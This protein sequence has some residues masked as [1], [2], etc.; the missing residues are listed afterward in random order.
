VQYD[1]HQTL[2]LAR[3]TRLHVGNALNRLRVQSTVAHNPKSPD[4]FG[5]Q[6]CSVG[7]KCNRPR[8]LEITGEHLDAK[9]SLFRRLNIKRSVRELGCRPHDRRRRVGVVQ[10]MWCKRLMTLL[11]QTSRSRENRRES[12]SNRV[13]TTTARL[14]SHYPLPKATCI[15]VFR[16]LKRGGG[17]GAMELASTAMP[18]F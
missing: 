6:D 1:V 15:P 17:L 4:T 12:D 16:K 13:M 5:D 14:T 8:L 3:S 7:Q 18:G 9:V 10:L 2:K 11:S